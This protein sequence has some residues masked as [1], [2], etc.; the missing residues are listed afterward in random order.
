VLR[1]NEPAKGKWFVPGGLVRKYVRLADAFAR[2][3]KTEI[4]IVLIGDTMVAM[5]QYRH[6]RLSHN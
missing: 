5:C 1:T 4:G 6:H 3:V 2:I